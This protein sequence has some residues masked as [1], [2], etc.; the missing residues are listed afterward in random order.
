MLHSPHQLVEAHEADATDSLEKWF[1]A[2][3]GMTE[4][5]KTGPVSQIPWGRI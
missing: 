2:V 4:R 5:R 3:K 1:A